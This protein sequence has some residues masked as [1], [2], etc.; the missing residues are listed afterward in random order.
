MRP[1]FLSAVKPFRAARQ[2]SPSKASTPTTISAS[3]SQLATFITVM[4]ATPW[5]RLRRQT[6][7]IRAKFGIS[8]PFG[9]IHLKFLLALPLTG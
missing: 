9:K 4:R 2:A 5:T 3:A 7:L 6:G 1:F 8:T